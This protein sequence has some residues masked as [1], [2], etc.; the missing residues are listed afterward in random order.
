MD[1]PKGSAEILW[2]KLKEFDNQLDQYHDYLNKQPIEEQSSESLFGRMITA[3]K[4]VLNQTVEKASVSIIA[5]DLKTKCSQINKSFKMG[6]MTNTQHTLL[7]VEVARISQK[8]E[9]LSN[10]IYNPQQNIEEKQK[11]YIKLSSEKVAD[12]LFQETV[13]LNQRYDS[14][15]VLYLNDLRQRSL[16][17]ANSDNQNFILICILY[18][19]T[20]NSLNLTHKQRIYLTSQLERSMLT[21]VQTKYQL[22][23]NSE[24]CANK[25]MEELNKYPVGKKE[26]ALFIED[27]TGFIK[28]K[29]S[30]DPNFIKSIESDVTLIGKKDSLKLTQEEEEIF[31]LE[32]SSEPEQCPAKEKSIY[33]NIKGLFLRE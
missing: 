16:N 17:D 4:S 6:E 27:F 13:R 1:A 2:D 15:V 22:P 21:Y 10:R 3:G 30:F 31:T 32:K 11:S 23:A 24:I 20:S 29:Y 26:L 33:E 7:F 12:D 19:F 8:I 18:V 5:L 9:N 25:L 14:A 28:K